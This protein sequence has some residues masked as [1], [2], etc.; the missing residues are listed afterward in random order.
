LEKGL[1]GDRRQRQ[2]AART[3]QLQANRNQHT[4]RAG[5]LV[6]ALV[7]ACLSLGEVQAGWDSLDQRVTLQNLQAMWKDNTK[8]ATQDVVN[9]LNAAMEEAQIQ[10]VRCVSCSLLL[11]LLCSQMGLRWQLG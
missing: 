4:M 1:K 10:T 2:P 9:Q 7:S 8:Y 3:T 6:H 5:L 11:V